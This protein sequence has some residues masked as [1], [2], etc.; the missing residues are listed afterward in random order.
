MPQKRLSRSRSHDRRRF[1]LPSLKVSF[2]SFLLFR[3]SLYSR[4]LCS[5]SCAPFFVVVPFAVFSDAT[6]HLRDICAQPLESSSLFPRFFL[7]LGKSRSDSAFPWRLAFYDFNV[8]SLAN[9]KG[10]PFLLQDLIN[11][12][13]FQGYPWD[14]SIQEPGRRLN[15]Y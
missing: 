8:A 1:S 6:P 12:V 2:S 10:L 3:W 11:G 14:V 5:Q 7:L 13:D 15:P 4:S 9:K